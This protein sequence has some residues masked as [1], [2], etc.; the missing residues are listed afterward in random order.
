MST[1]VDQA[2]DDGAENEQRGKTNLGQHQKRTNSFKSFVSYSRALLSR[3]VSH[4][5]T[6]RIAVV[7]LILFLT[8][9]AVSFGVA[10]TV[11]LVP[12]APVWGSVA[13]WVSAI[14][15][16]FTGLVTLGAF[17]VAGFTYAYYRGEA[18]RQEDEATSEQDRAEL[19][20]ERG[21]RE[22]MN[23]AWQ[24]MV[25]EVSLV[26]ILIEKSKYAV[27]ANWGE[28]SYAVEP[29]LRNRTG[30]I[31]TDIEMSVDELR[32]GGSPPVLV[33]ATTSVLSDGARELIWSKELDARFV[34][35]DNARRQYNPWSTGF[36]RDPSVE[37]DGPSGHRTVLDGKLRFRFRIGNGPRWVLTYTPKSPSLPVLDL[38]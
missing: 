38:E 26:E 18:Q 37:G 21:S 4:P 34:G 28:M 6:K 19:E 11:Q 1:V 12:Y 24:G 35:Q 25:D 15:G 17:V 9:L 16:W 13:D 32:I 20:F 36:R 14:A 33:S 10:W 22:T 7:S 3:F 31:L 27:T 23:D 8:L 2:S 29:A 30:K 5:Q